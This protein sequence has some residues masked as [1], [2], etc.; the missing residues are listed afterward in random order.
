MSWGDGI[1]ERAES[2]RRIRRVLLKLGMISSVDGKFIED[3]Y[4]QLLAY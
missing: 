1:E 3:H 2:L 4:W